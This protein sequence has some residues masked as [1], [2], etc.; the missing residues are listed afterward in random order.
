MT[1]HLTILRL[2]SKLS[3][4]RSPWPPLFLP[5]WPPVW[6]TFFY[7]PESSQ[8]PFGTFKWHPTWLYCAFYQN[9]KNGGHVD[10]HFIYLG[11]L[12]CGLHLFST[13]NRVRHPLEPLKWQPNWPMC[14]LYP[15]CKNG[16]HFDLHFFY[17]GDLQCG[18][19]LFSTWNRVRHLLEP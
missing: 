2:I 17:L 16:G 14:A 6:C 3:K 9:L 7:N 8:A 18:V 15:N 10:L 1:P 11:D 13:R 12:Q 5:S 19:H 4:W